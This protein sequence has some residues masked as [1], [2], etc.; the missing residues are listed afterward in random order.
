[1]R[2]RGV[3]KFP[4]EIIYVVEPAALC[5]VAIEHAKRRP[6]SWLHRL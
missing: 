5:I 3:G 2:R 1:V 6:G 4:Y